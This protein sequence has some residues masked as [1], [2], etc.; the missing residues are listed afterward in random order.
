[1]AK[2]FK[3]A[4]PSADEL[5]ERVEAYFKHCADSRQELPLR[6]GDIRIRQELPSMVGL[7]LWLG[8]HRDTL[9]SYINGT[10]GTNGLD[11][12]EHKTAS[13]ILARAQLRIHQATMIA[14]AN[15][16]MDSRTAAMLLTNYGYARAADDSPT[17]TVRIDSGSS[18]ADWAG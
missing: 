15:G 18:G 4:F 11:A 8:V 9:Y 5:D 12:E 14:A 16:D 10:D 13:D 1:M 2:R 6:N 3:T 17:V 7:A